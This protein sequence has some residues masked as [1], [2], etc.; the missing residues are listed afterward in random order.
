MRRA[1]HAAS[2]REAVGGVREFAHF[3]VRRTIKIRQRDISEFEEGLNLLIDSAEIEIS[4]QYEVSE[5]SQIYHELQLQAFESAR[6]KAQAL[7]EYAGDSIGKALE[8]SEFPPEY[9][10]ASTAI[11]LSMPRS[12]QSDMSSPEAR[13][14]QSVVYVMFELK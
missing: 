10:R 1:G 12:L 11:G 6:M 8:I 5:A 9:G 2:D 13:L 14:L 3:Q 7:A 4:F